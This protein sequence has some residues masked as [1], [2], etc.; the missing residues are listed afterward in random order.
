MFILLFVAPPGVQ[1]EDLPPSSWPRCPTRPWRR[2]RSDVL[3]FRCS[4]VASSGRRLTSSR[5]HRLSPPPS[6]PMMGSSP[7]PAM[8]SSSTAWRRRPAAGWRHRRGRAGAVRSVRHCW[9]RRTL[10]PSGRGREREG[11]RGGSRKAGCGSVGG[12]GR[13]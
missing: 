5:R 13:W 7:R 8:K 10:L 11:R 2:P 6:R 9:R 3:S 4:T 1:T 12:G